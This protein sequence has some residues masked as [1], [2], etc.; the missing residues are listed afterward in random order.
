MRKKV[1]V[2]GAGHVG[3]STAMYLAERNIC[4]ITLVDIIEDM[5]KGKA[6]DLAQAGP[7]RNY[8]A[9][10]IGSSDFADIKGAHIVVVTSGVPR[11]P[12]MT[13]EDLITKNAEIVGSVTEN[14]KKYAPDAMVLMVANPLDIMTFH[15]WKKMGV[16]HRLVFG[17]A[18]VLDSVRFRTFV[19]WELGVS[20]TDVQAMVLGGHGDT[21]VPLPRYTTVAGIPITELIAPDRIEAI[22]KRTRDGGG[23]IVKLLKTGS[24]YYAPAAATVEMVD[25]ILTDRKRVMPCSAYLTGQY[26][27]KDLYIGVPAVL[28]ARGVEKVIEL[29]LNDQEIAELQKSAAIYKEMLSVL[30]Y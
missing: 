25:S 26:G 30:G 18:G 7:I 24:A 12:G 6:L 17:Q 16:D 22:S 11:K 29:K 4:D 8:D 20:P 10:I 23:E 14:I 19:G 3:E 5:P 13:R 28:G 27:I 15:S 21:M 9:A 1:A 2:I